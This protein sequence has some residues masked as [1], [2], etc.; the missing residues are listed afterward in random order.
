MATRSFAPGKVLRVWRACGCRTGPAP[1]PGL[2]PDGAPVVTAR[3]YGRSHL[4]PK[5]GH[6]EW[7]KGKA[8]HRK[9]RDLRFQW[10]GWPDLNRR[11][12]RPELAAPLGVRPSSQLAECATGRRCWRLCG[13]VAVLPCCTV[14]RISSS[15]RSRPDRFRLDRRVRPVLR[16]RRRMALSCNPNCNPL[17]RPGIRCLGSSRAR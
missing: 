7:R 6:W 4:V 3:N 15:G 10:S 17:I 1:Q 13:D 5:I 14:Y 12:L 8:G 2:P 11:P 9:S 16:E